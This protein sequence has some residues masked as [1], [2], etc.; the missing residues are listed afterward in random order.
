MVVEDLTVLAGTERSVMLA[1]EGLKAAGHRLYLLHTGQGMVDGL[2]EDELALPDL[3]DMAPYFE[4]AAVRAD[5][6][7]LKEFISDH[8]IEIMHLHTVLRFG[9]CRRLLTRIPMVFTV[10][11]VLCPNGARYLWNERRVCDREIGIGCLTV[12][13]TTKGCGHLGNSE[14]T[15]LG[16]FSRAM[17]QDRR[18]RAEVAR[19][20]RVIAPSHWMGKYL[21]SNGT[22]RS[23]IRVVEP[24]IAAQRPTASSTSDGVPILSFVGRLVDFKG[25]D[26]LLRASALL[27]FEHRVVIAGGGPLKEQLRRLANEIGIGH[28]VSMPGQLSPE[29]ADSLRLR[30]SVMVVPSMLPEAYGMVGPEALAL[31][32]PVAGYRVGGST[33]WLALGAPLTA[34]VDPG[35]VGGLARAIR[36]MVLKPPSDEERRSV[37]ERIRATLA[38]SRHGDRLLSVYREAVAE[39]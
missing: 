27:D 18:I 1:T 39:F 13:Y 9:V 16:G 37:A 34:E 15:G 35:D 36:R 22:S 4:H 28:R 25:A 6:S 12:G 19:C 5:L 29:E 26:Q 23:K 14:P 11:V 38:V 21:E 30:S 17:V 2:V 31:G 7:R 3:F 10:H 8:D 33:E 32:I 24:P 20:H